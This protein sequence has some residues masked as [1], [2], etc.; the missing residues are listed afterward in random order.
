MLTVAFI[1]HH[2]SV[3]ANILIDQTGNP[4]L[5]DFGL[6]I[7]ISDPANLL[8]SSSCVQG[9]TPRWMSPEL[10]SPEEFGLK[11]SRPTKSS[12]CYSLGMVIYET[13]SGN[14][15]FHEDTD[16]AVILKVMKGVR[17]RRTLAFEGLWETLQ[18]CWVAEPGKRPSIE[19][20]LQRLDVCQTSSVPTHGD[21]MRSVRVNL[22]HSAEIL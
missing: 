1:S 22:V 21:V 10:L 6:L 7:I 5:V 9:G 18:E 16:A 19:V 8:F 20:I 11:T 14:A 12:D 3:K 15:P 4:R 17:P 13:I 2:M